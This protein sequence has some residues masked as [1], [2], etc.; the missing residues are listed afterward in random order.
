LFIAANA[1]V[2][3][4]I[5]WKALVFLWWIPA[6]ASCWGVAGAVIT[7]HWGGSANNGWKHRWFLYYEAL[8]KHHHDYP[9]APNTAINPGEVDY[10]YQASRVFLPKYNWEG[11]PK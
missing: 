10:T 2:L 9:R 8:H 1:F 11:Q 7:Q 5:S 4:L 3:Y 6:S